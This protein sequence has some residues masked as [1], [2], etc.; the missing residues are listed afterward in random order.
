M[1]YEKPSGPEVN[2]SREATALCTSNHKCV[3]ISTREEKG[4]PL[5]RSF[6]GRTR[7]GLTRGVPLCR[8]Q[9]LPFELTASGWLSG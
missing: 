4:T 3:L 6:F 9:Y 1:P 7:S 2:P 8:L 5:E